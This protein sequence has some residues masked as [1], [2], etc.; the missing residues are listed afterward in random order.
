M[1]CLQ[2]YR[3]LLSLTTFLQVHSNSKEVSFLS[4][5]NTYPI[6]KTTCHNKLNFFPC[7][8]NSQRIYS[9]QNISYLSLHSVQNISNHV[10]EA[11][12]GGVLLKSCYLKFGKF[13][14]KRLCQSFFFLIKS[15]TSPCNFIKKQALAQ[16]LSHEFRAI[17][18]N[19]F[20][21]EHLRW[22]LLIY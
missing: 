7:E 18:K 12:T 22:L 4:C 3:E 5:Q 13:T 16:V 19:T 1:A 9:L 11:A 10:S 20:F 2:I 17:F 15:Q 6:S 14:E 21:R 8:R